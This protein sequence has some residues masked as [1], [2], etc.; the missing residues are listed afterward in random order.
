M[1]QKEKGRIIYLGLKGDFKNPEHYFREVNPDNTLGAKHT[2]KNSLFKRASIGTVYDVEFKN[3]RNTVSYNQSNTGTI[4]LESDEGKLL[5]TYSLFEEEIDQARLNTEV[6]KNAKKEKSKPTQFDEALSQLN[7][8]YRKAHWQNR[9]AFLA[10][11][12]SK[13]TK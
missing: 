3:N 9:T 5:T 10:Y 4:Y 13:I 12:I 7:E 11:C 2:Y 1:E 8:Q 6:I